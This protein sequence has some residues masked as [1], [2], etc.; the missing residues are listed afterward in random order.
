MPNARTLEIHRL[1]QAVLK[2]GMDKDM[3]RLWAERALR[4]V[5][6]AFPSGEFSTWAVCERLLPQAYACAE[7][8]KQWSFG[9]PEAARLL[10][11]VGLYLEERARYTDVEPLFE[12]ALAIREKAL[13]VEH[14]NVARSLSSLSG[15]YNSQGG[16]WGAMEQKTGL[17]T[18][19]RQPPDV[20]M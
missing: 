9:F 17:S 6:R 10:N 2:Q 14:P 7:L 4:A 16:V 3:Q 1:V 13:G 19:C 15:L 8:I 18:G 5:N 11:D 20:A 12:R